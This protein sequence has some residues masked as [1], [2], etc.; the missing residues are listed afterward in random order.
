MNNKIAGVTYTISCAT[1]VAMDVLT[2]GHPI[3]PIQVAV[4]LTS[5]AIGLGSILYL[6][7]NVS[8]KK[9]D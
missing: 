1:T 3:D 8:G 2:N 4:G 6:S 5:G 9:E 7:N